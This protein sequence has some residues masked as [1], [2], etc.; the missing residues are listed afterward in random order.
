MYNPR[1]TVSYSCYCLSIDGAMFHLSGFQARASARACGAEQKD[2]DRGALRRLHGCG[3]TVRCQTGG[4]QGVAA[5]RLHQI[6]RPCRGSCV[7]AFLPNEV[8]AK[9]DQL[10]FV[11]STPATSSPLVVFLYCFCFCA[12]L[13]NCLLCIIQCAIFHHSPMNSGSVQHLLEF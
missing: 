8:C 2:C 11:K 13:I 5:R 6:H 1:T 10:G 4:R 7:A 3:D 9:T 12:I